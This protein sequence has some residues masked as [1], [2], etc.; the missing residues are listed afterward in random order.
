MHVVLVDEL[1]RGCF[2]A[3]GWY[4]VSELWQWTTIVTVTSTMIILYLS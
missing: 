3:M 4:V 1:K 2:N